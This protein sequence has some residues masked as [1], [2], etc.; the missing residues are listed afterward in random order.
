MSINLF[1]FNDE[2][3]IAEVFLIKQTQEVTLLVL[4]NKSLCLCV[5]W[6]FLNAAEATCLEHIVHLIFVL[7]VDNRI[8]YIILIIL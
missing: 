6:V 8:Y 1:T 2:N 7:R 5:E 4:F 3:N